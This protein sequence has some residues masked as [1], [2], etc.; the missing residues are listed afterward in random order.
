MPRHA[1]LIA[2]LN[3]SLLSCGFTALAQSARPPAAPEAN[4]GMPDAQG[5]SAS[6]GQQPP[7]PRL[8][9][10]ISG[11][12][13]DQTGV[14]VPGARVR[15]S[16]EDQ[17]PDREALSGDDGQFSF[18]GVAPGPF[19][20]TITSAGFATQASSGI[21]PSGE[22]YNVPQITLALAT[23]A[24]EVRVIPSPTEVAEDQIKVQEKQ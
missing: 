22:T 17:S 2:L 18:A 9:G 20:L 10:S 24:M 16:R 21:L 6:S 5:A 4:S 11:T 1:V 19:Q 7:D 13:V 12:V 23:A 14:A 8:S 3:L 15:L